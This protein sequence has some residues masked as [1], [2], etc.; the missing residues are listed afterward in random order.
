MKSLLWLGIP[1]DSQ[2]L[3][4]VYSLFLAVDTKQI[5]EKWFDLILYRWL[6]TRSA[7]W[8]QNKWLAVS[9]S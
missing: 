9:I 3:A 4:P 2:I 8:A 5:D 6:L 7:E 1:P